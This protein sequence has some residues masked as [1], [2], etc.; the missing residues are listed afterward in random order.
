LTDLDLQKPAKTCKKPT[1]TCKN[2]QKT[3]KNLQKLSKNIQKTYKNPWV[4]DDLS[5]IFRGSYWISL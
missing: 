5:A 2:L 4:V 1:K 3:R